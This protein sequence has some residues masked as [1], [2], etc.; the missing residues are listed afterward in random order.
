MSA[1]GLLAA[2]LMP[3]FQL[4]GVGISGYNLS[5][6]GAYGNYAWAIPIL[7]GATILVSSLE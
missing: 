3:W 1:F 4:F 6:L 7:T 5:K 2:F